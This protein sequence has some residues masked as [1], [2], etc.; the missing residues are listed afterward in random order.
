MTKRSKCENKGIVPTEMELVL[1]EEQLLFLAGEQ[2][3]NF[4]EDVDDL[5]LNVDHVF[6]ADQCDAFDSDVD[7][8]PTTQ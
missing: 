3:T 2:F 4:D 1:E 5:T 8:A 6:E 7:E